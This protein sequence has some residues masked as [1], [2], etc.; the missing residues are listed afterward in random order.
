MDLIMGGVNFSDPSSGGDECFHYLTVYQRLVETVLVLPVAI[1]QLCYIWPKARSMEVPHAPNFR[2]YNNC[3]KLGSFLLFILILVFAVEVSYKVRTGSLIFLLNPCHVATMLEILLFCENLLP[4]NVARLVFA[5]AMYFLPGATL[6]LLFPV[7]TSRKLP[8]EVCIY[9][10]QHLTIVLCPVYLLSLGGIYSA[11]SFYNFNIYVLCHAL[12]T[13]YSFGPLQLISMLTNVNLNNVLCPASSDPFQGYYYRLAAIA[14]HSLFL[15]LHSW[16]YIKFTRMILDAFENGLFIPTQL[17]EANGNKID[18]PLRFSHCNSMVSLKQELQVLDYFGAFCVFISF[19]VIILII[20]VTCIL[21]FCVSPTDDV[22]V[23]AKKTILRCQGGTEAAKSVKR[24]RKEKEEEKKSQ[25]RR[26]F[27]GRRCSCLVQFPLPCPQIYI[28]KHACFAEGRVVALLRVSFRTTSQT[29]HT[30]YLPYS[31]V[32]VFQIQ[33]IQSDCSCERCLAGG[34]SLA[35]QD[36]N[37]LRAINCFLPRWE[38]QQPATVEDEQNSCVLERTELR[39]RDMNELWDQSLPV[40][41]M[42][43]AKLSRLKQLLYL[44]NVTDVTLNRYNVRALPSLDGLIFPRYSVTLE[45]MGSQIRPSGLKICRLVETINMMTVADEV[46]PSVSTFNG[47]FGY[48]LVR[49]SDSEVVLTLNEADAMSIFQACSK[50]AVVLPDNPGHFNV[51]VVI[52]ICQISILIHNSFEQLFLPYLEEFTKI[53]LWLPPEKY[54]R[55]K[56]LSKKLLSNQCY[57][58]SPKACN[59]LR[60]A[61]TLAIP[62]KGRELINGVIRQGEAVVHKYVDTLAMLRDPVRSFL[63]GY[64]GQ[65]CGVVQWKRFSLLNSYLKGFRLG[66]L[67]LLTGPFGCGKKTFL[68]EY[69]LDLCDQNMVTLWCGLELP[70]IRVVA[71]MIEQYARRISQGSLATAIIRLLAIEYHASA[72]DVQHV[73]IDNALLIHDCS[74]QTFTELKRFASSK[75]LHI[76]AIVH[77]KKVP[78]RI[79]LEV[80]NPIGTISAYSI[81]SSL[82]GAYEAD[83]ILQITTHINKNQQQQCE[84]EKYL[85]IWK[86]RNVGELLIGCLVEM[87]FDPLSKCHSLVMR[88]KKIRPGCVD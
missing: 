21:W 70:S 88:K 66:E 13:L 9:W 38:K 19:F 75:N 59:N 4:P 20:S 14:H 83:N 6:A 48:H 34:L 65:T 11:E 41:H 31:V 71:T 18:P 46:L 43:L 36:W 39:K 74:S 55:A 25:F 10:I 63:F 72:Q 23:F 22:T 84:L 52:P 50:L 56:Q 78:L 86:N 32:V 53:T 29:T 28:I 44:R 33:I 45:M 76:T 12:M 2:A 58:I 1:L 16:L 26:T 68:C 54:N 73:V 40:S 24:N 30:P 5:L 57:L 77:P 80:E 15:I 79:L 87:H 3:K 64:N 67:T 17:L 37:A 62:G 85:Q 69:A 81:Y 8:G 51:E 27:S 42:S 7:V 61:E 35:L 49:Q 60:A 82:I 47:M